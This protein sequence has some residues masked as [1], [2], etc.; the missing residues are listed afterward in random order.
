MSSYDCSS[1]FIS[2]L[3]CV[4][5][6]GRNTY[7]RT[8]SGSEDFKISRSEKSEVDTS[9]DLDFVQEG[10]SYKGTIWGSRFQD[11]KEKVKWT[12]EVDFSLDILRHIDRKM[13]SVAFLL[14]LWR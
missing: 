9:S 11:F 4:V 10:R 14:I 5:Q 8:L 12:R 1:Y 3:K 2:Y 7:I 13:E 6:E